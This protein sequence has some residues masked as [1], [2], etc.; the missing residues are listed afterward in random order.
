[1]LSNDGQIMWLEQDGTWG[2]VALV[3]VFCRV[4]LE[5]ALAK[6]L[7]RLV[8]SPADNFFLAIHSF[9]RCQENAT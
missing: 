7:G 3:D 9:K 5:T 6:S 8:S 1:M 4:L 2:W